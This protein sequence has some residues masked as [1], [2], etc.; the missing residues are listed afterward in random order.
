MQCV[1][2]L[3][4]LMLTLDSFSQRLPPI[5]M[6]PFDL[7]SRSSQLLI[8]HSSEMHSPIHDKSPY[9]RHKGLSD[10]Y[11]HDISSHPPYSLDLWWVLWR[12]RFRHHFRNAK[13]KTCLQL[14]KTITQRSLHSSSNLTALIVIL[15][16][17]PRTLRLTVTRPVISHSA[18]ITRPT[19]FSDLVCTV[20]DTIVNSEFIPFSL[21]LRS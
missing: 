3:A 1:Y 21:N 18:L 8:Y 7:V 14:G 11:Q 9:S 4:W 10:D 12:H 6:F 16:S 20:P 13:P 17:G 15:W 19:L 2:S 5:E